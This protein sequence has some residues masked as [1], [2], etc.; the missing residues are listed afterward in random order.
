MRRTSRISG[1][2]AE[3]TPPAMRTADGYPLKP[4]MVV[5]SVSSRYATEL[6]IYPKFTVIGVDEANRTARL[7]CDSTGREHT[8]F[9]TDASPMLFAFLK[10]AVEHRKPQLEARLKELKKKA[11]SA[12]QE[13][14]RFHK[15]VIS[16]RAGKLP[17]NIE[18]DD[19]S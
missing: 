6:L 12:K 3:T 10:N 18:T 14:D 2:K 17:N 9:C 8:Y 16:L 5:S 11:E 7:R 13:L 1:F 4:D 19:E 15:A